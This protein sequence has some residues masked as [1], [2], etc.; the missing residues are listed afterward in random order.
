MT[1]HHCLCHECADV[2]AAY[3]KEQKRRTEAFKKW[4]F[5]ARDKMMEEHKRLE[6]QAENRRRKGG[7]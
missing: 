5:P 3:F 4:Y 1:C 6:I 2:H 7:Q